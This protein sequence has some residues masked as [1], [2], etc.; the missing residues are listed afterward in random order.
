MFDAFKKWTMSG[1]TFT[2]VKLD[3]VEVESLGPAT[4]QFLEPEDG[5]SEAAKVR[6]EDE[7]EDRRNSPREGV[8]R[9]KYKIIIIAPCYPNPVFEQFAEEFPG[10]FFGEP[11]TMLLFAS[12]CCILL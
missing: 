4:R 8:L 6:E 3:A 11:P 7:G 9:W 5:A 10:I 2:S 1:H 12:N